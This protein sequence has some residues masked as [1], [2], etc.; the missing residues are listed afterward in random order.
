MKKP[1]MYKRYVTLVSLVFKGGVGFVRN[2]FKKKSCGA[3]PLKGEIINV[4]GV[5][6]ESVTADLRKVLLVDSYN[7]MR[8]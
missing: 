8:N 6:V 1:I 2:G 3:S 5:T 4:T 7:R